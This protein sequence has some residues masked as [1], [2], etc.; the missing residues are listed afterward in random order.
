MTV[1]SAK[2]FYA[3]AFALT[4]AAC[5]RSPQQQPAAPPPSAAPE[6]V[7]VPAPQPPPPP[8]IPPATELPLNT[9]DS[10]MLS[11]PQDEPASIVIHVSGTAPS[12]GWTDPKLTE[13]RDGSDAGV[14]T[15][16]FVA[17]SPEMPDEN[18]TPQSL[19]AEVRI[20]MLSPD[21]KSIRIVS[22]T[23]EVSAPVAQ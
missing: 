22:A 16:K 8:A 3:V 4:L 6:A 13:E 21:V 12:P 17:T 5:N 19:E 18:H 9:V 1:R 10:V 23:N 2:F 7:P 15:Y 11:R 14:K 20:D